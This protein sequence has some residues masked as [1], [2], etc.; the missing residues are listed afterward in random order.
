M[1]NLAL[2]NVFAKYWPLKVYGIL[3][4]ELFIVQNVNYVSVGKMNGTRQSVSM[5]NVFTSTTAFNGVVL[6]IAFMFDQ[7]YI[8]HEDFSTVPMS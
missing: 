8:S 2:K 1:F 5:S 7:A 4:Y 6:Y 3:K